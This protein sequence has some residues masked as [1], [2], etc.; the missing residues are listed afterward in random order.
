MKKYKNKRF[1][2]PGSTIKWVSEDLEYI[3][4]RTKQAKRKKINSDQAADE[5]L[6]I[7]DGG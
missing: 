2:R 7:L 5:L 4:Q 3:E 1:G 6:K